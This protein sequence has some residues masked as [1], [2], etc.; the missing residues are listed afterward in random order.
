MTTILEL[1][2]E[3]HRDLLDIVDKLRAQ[4]ISRYV[5]LP[6]IAVCGDQ[7]AGKSSVLEAISG[8]SFP[9][10]DNLCTRFATELILRRSSTAGATV[11]ITPD[12]DRSAAERAKLD[13]FSQVLDPEKPDLGDVIEAA[14]AAMGIDDAGG[15]VFATD[16]LRVELSG[17][18]QP[19]LTLVDL[20]GLFNTGN[21]DQSESDAN[22]V[23]D[24][25]FGYIKRPRC[26]ILAVVSAGAVFNLQVVTKYTRRVDRDGKRTLGLITK[27]D[28][29]PAGSRNERD[30]VALA[31]NR[32][33]R[34]DLGWHV[35]KN[36][37]FAAQGTTA[38]ERDASERDFFASAP[39]WAAVPPEQLG[40]AALRSRLSAVLRDLVVRQLPRVLASVEAGVADCNARLAVLGE[41]RDSAA[42]R[43]GYV[44]HASEQFWALM[45]AAIDG[46]YFD[47]FFDGPKGDDTYSKRLRAVVQNRLDE[48]EVTM[49]G[50][51]RAQVIVDDN[52]SDGEAEDGQEVVTRSDYISHV[53]VLMKASRGRELRGTFNPIIVGMLFREQCRPWADLAADL[54]EDILE[55]V[56]RAV[57]ALLEHVV[58]GGVPGD[59]QRDLVGPKMEILGANLKKK[60]K[61]LLEPHILGYP[62]THN[63]DLVHKVQST[64]ARRLRIKLEATFVNV[65][66]SALT[67]QAYINTRELFDAVYKD[68]AQLMARSPSSVAVEYMEAYYDVSPSSPLPPHHVHH[69]RTPAKTR[70]SA[71][72]QAVHRRHQLARHRAV[73]AGA[74]ARPLLAAR[75]LQPARR[76]DR[77]AGRRAAGHGRGAR[78]ADQEAQRPD[79]RAGRADALP[80]PEVRVGRKGC[81]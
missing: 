7:S 30:Y 71:H 76:A 29:L 37:D 4:G 5:D 74:P 65:T 59:I 34:F 6:E 81:W 8:L 63:D 44:L 16:V 58:V 53:E 2:S 33:V 47:G 19:H 32:D 52:E 42:Q 45:R 57:R 60:V 12:P 28:L 61:E 18:T 46:A 17:P 66:R 62:I 69:G 54:V 11:S 49:Q 80:P 70:S 21:K 55:R 77:R 40:V 64:Q 15:K 39:A 3:A 20:P 50:R 13:R 14:K 25:V 31:R 38:A 36:R 10:Q 68:T 22:L 23:K 72:P 73:P 26:I 35:L 79:Q 9:A 78:A 75:R 56:N 1:Q 24:M 51:G 43:R 67:T 41:A 27:P 48:F